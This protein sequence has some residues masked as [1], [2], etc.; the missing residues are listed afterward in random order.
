[1]EESREMCSGLAA[2]LDEEGKCFE[3]E[4]EA[5]GADDLCLEDSL[6]AGA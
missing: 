5:F 4:A 2:V 1:M 6:T 3:V